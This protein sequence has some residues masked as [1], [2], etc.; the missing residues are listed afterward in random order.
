MFKFVAGPLGGY[1]AGFSY[2]GTVLLT[3]SGMMG[4]VLVFTYLGKALKKYVINN[5]FKNR[6][7][8]TPRN[9]KFVAVWRKY[10]TNGVAFL[11]PVILT[12]IGGTLL[13]T[14]MGTP[15]KT[16]VV[17]ML[18]SA[19]FWSFIITGVIYFFGEEVVPVLMDLTNLGPEES[20]YPE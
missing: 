19:V 15:R 9:R 8:F 4:S 7:K 11:T 14:S 18:L 1:V 20:Q 2:L 17:T 10:G 3:A 13:M 5:L 16:I 6:K 12:P